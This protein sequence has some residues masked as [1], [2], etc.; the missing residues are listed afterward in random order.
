L[1]L[2]ATLFAYPTHFRSAVEIPLKRYGRQSKQPHPPPRFSTT[3][4]PPLPPASSPSTHLNGFRPHHLRYLEP[5]Y[6]ANNE[7]LLHAAFKDRKSTRLNST[8]VKIS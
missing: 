5:L 8:H 3:H 7:T 6:A 4:P 1:R 2:L